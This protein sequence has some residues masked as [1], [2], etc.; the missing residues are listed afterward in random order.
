LEP[1]EKE[2]VV[3]AE[4]FVPS[5]AVE[6]DHGAL[7]SGGRK[8]SPGSEIRYSACGSILQINEALQL[9]THFSGIVGGYVVMNTSPPGNARCLPRL[10]LRKSW[11]AHRVTGNQ[12]GVGALLCH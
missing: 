6:Q 5:L 4:Q 1:K 7:G 10:I 8:H 12:C 9:T 11:K 2:F 3:S